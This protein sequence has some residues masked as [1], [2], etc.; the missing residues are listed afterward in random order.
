MEGGIKTGDLGQGWVD[1]HQGFYRQEIV[2]LVQG[3]QGLEGAERLKNVGID[4]D[5]GAEGSAAMHDTVT[6]QQF[7][8]RVYTGLQPVQ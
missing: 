2:R 6:D 5:R 4:P 8:V 3:G 1:L 7:G